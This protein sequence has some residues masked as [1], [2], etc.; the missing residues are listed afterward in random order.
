[1]KH[2]GHKNS[3]RPKDIVQLEQ[4]EE[5]LEDKYFDETVTISTSNLRWLMQKSRLWVQ[6][7]NVDSDKSERTADYRRTLVK[8]AIRIGLKLYRPDDM[9]ISELEALVNQ[10]Y[11]NN[12]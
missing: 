12:Q 1:M 2:I 4:L 6:R 7:G 3:G 9:K 8:E 5:A 11:K 10:H